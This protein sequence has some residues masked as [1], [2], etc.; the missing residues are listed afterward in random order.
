[1]ESAIPKLLQCPRACARRVPDDYTPPYPAW[2]A[3]HRQSVK[4]VVMAY[5]GVQSKGPDPQGFLSWIADEFRREGGPGHWDRARYSDEAGYDTVI[6]IAYW[7]DPRS[8]DAWMDQPEFRGWWESEARS[9]ERLGY[10]RE[11]IRPRV[12]RFETLFSTPDKPEGIAVLAG[13]MSGE[14]REHGYWGGAR[15][16]IPLS[17]IEALEP[18]GRPTRVSLNGKRVIV[19]PQGNLCLIRSG[20]DWTETVGDERR[21]YLAE[22]EPVLREGM[23]YLRDQGLRIGCYANRYMKIID[24]QGVEREKSFGMSYF[25]SLAELERWAESHS[26]HVAIFGT[27]MRIVEQ[28]NFQLKLRLYHEVTVAAADEQFFEYINCHDQTGLLRAAA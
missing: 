14:L 10:F 11:I 26:T 12:E 15:D 9:S 3:R 16:R 4:Q 6:S 28:L 27:F 25:R 21:M 18:A 20:Q 2:C 8:F 7:D 5:F 17:Q 13:T 22:M 19:Q 23:N 24:E 1:M